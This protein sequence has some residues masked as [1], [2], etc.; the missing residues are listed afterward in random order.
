MRNI[1]FSAV[2][3]VMF[4]TLA[5]S[6]PMP[7]LWQIGTKDNSAEEFALG[8]IYQTVLIEGKSDCCR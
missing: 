8:P 2:A 3:S 4:A 7:V 1:F 6:Q 5:F